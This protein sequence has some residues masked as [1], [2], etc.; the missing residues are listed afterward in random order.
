MEESG[1]KERDGCHLS[2]SLSETGC[3]S[4]LKAIKLKH[5]NTNKDWINMQPHDR[6]DFH[7]DVF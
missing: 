3:I 6:T 5:I 7:N 4:H 1:R 2:A